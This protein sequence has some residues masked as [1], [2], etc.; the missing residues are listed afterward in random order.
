LHTGQNTVLVRN[1]GALCRGSR[2]FVWIDMESPQLLCKG[3]RAVKTNLKRQFQPK[4][5]WLTSQQ[6]LAKIQLELIAQW[7][8]YCQNT[9]LMQTLGTQC[10]S[11]AYY[12][13]SQSSSGCAVTLIVTAPVFLA[14]ADPA[15]RAPSLTG[16]L[17]ST[18]A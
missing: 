10:M 17:A 13:N 16:A 2:A 8:K 5:L 1:L 11:H 6:Y 18:S 15:E 4:F 3:T 12:C 9:V 7:P 14:G